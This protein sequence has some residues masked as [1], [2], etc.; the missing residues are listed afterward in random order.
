GIGPRY[1]ADSYQDTQRPAPE[2]IN[3]RHRV[4]PNGQI[5]NLNRQPDMDAIIR[6]GGYEALHYFDGVGDGWVTVECPQ[7][8]GLVDAVVPAYCTVGLPDFFP[9]VTQRDLMTWWRTEV[10]EPIRDALWAIHPLA[11]SQTR[12]AANITL[13]IG[14]SLEDTTITAIVTQPTD[15]Q[16]E[17][18]Q[19]NG[20]WEVRKTG[21]PDGSPGVFDPGWDTSQG[22]YYTDPSRPLQKFMAG[23]GLGSP[24][25]EDTKLCAAL[26]AYWP[27]V[28][29]DSTRT[30]VPDKKIEGAFYPYPTIVPL[31]DQEIG[32]APLDDGT[33][34]PWDGVR[35]PRLMAFDNR[36]VVAYAN[37]ERVDYIDL[38]GTMT[39]L[40]TSRVDTSEYKARIMAMQAVYWALGIHDP[41][42]VERFGK[43]TSTYKI[44]Q[45]KAAWAVLSFRLL[46]AD[47][48]GARAAEKATGHELSGSRRYAIQVYRWGKETP[49]PTDMHTI[50]VE[51]HELA[52][53]Y[54]SGNTVLIQRDGGPWGI[55][56]SMPT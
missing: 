22:I 21:L 27:G 25:I 32:S 9:K 28:A 47:D 42:F 24:F 43:P 19:P 48:A 31:T 50:F 36:R 18:Q 17:T 30:F 26:G 49:D 55:D 37:A 40:L 45:A 8:S 33:F 3:I 16:D 11:L 2:Y 1:M 54:V 41:A 38:L 44:L 10:P 14:F 5:V 15:R 20:P 6:R 7:L 39:A 23:Y 35:G 12:I 13:P 51:M 29:P 4:L 52:Q 56:Q 53:A 46:G 34:M